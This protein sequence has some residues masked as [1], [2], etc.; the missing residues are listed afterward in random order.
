MPGLLETALIQWQPVFVAVAISCVLG[1]CAQVIYLLR[2]RLAM[3]LG[4]R[5]RLLR[6]ASDYAEAGRRLAIY[7]KT[8]G[9]LAPWYFR[10]RLAEESERCRRYDRVFSLLALEVGPDESPLVNEW[11]TA[12]LRGTDLVCYDGS[13]RYFVLMPETTIVGASTLVKRILREFSG[14]RLSSATYPVEDERLK[15]LLIP[16]DAVSKKAA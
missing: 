13:G 12:S 8:T 10:L 4:H 14:I 3:S 1:V 6:Q 7:D 9:F 16:L 15:D 11:L 2:R 5:L